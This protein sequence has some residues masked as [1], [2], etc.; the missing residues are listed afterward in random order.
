[1]SSKKI[2]TCYACAAFINY[3]VSMVW[4]AKRNPKLAPMYREEKQIT[5]LDRFKAVG[6]L[7]PILLLALL[8]LGGI[9]S[10]IFTPA[11]AAAVGCIA[12]LILGVQQKGISSVKQ[13]KEA[14]RESANTC[15]M[16]FLIVVGALYYTRFL[17][18]TQI[19][20]R[21][22]MMVLALQAPPFV[23][24]LGIYALILPILFPLIVSPGTLRPRGYIH[25]QPENYAPRGPGKSSAA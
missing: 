15:S 14:L 9:Y 19:P 5:V 11:E 12:T 25:S 13:I 8:V 18:I 1:V 4:R 23:I 17:S 3:A 7:W 22:S 20:T 21:L 6:L 16:V 2:V 24:L 10:G